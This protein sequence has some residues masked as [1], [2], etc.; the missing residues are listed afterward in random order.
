S[1]R[2]ALFLFRSQAGLEAARHRA[3]VWA[4]H[5]LQLAVLESTEIGELDPRL[6][7]VAARMSGALYSTVDGIGDTQA[8]TR[9]LVG[10]GAE[11][12]VK[13][14]FDTVALSMRRAGTEITGV[15]TSRGDISADVYV[16]ATGVETGLLRDLE[17]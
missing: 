7:P 4:E 17:L 5:G 12:G 3:S 13:F 9:A 1:A 15:V 14:L 16:I 6:G 10:H 2:G 11:A 8:F